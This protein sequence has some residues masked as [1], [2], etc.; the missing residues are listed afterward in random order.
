MLLFPR[1]ESLL[2]PVTLCGTTPRAAISALPQHHLPHPHD[3]TKPTP[4]GPPDLPSEGSVSQLQSCL[5]T[6]IFLPTPPIL[7]KVVPPASRFR[8]WGVL[9]PTPLPG[10]RSYP[11]CPLSF[12]AHPPDFL[13][14]PWLLSPPL[15]DPAHLAPAFSYL[16]ASPSH[17]SSTPLGALEVWINIG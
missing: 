15:L 16:Q 2:F 17:P 10:S 1:A 12:S 13:S 14:L 11:S 8:P 3:D 4:E 6:E 7:L 5:E 9:K